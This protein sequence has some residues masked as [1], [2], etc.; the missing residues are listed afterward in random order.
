LFAQPP[1]LYPPP[2]LSP[3]RFLLRFRRVT[4][5]GGF[6]AEIDGL[7][8]IAIFVV[9][10]FHIAVG[11]YIKAPGRF[12]PPPGSA[13]ASV[14]WS[15]FR[16]VE[17]FFII[18]GF[19]LGMP[20]A[21]HHLKGGKKVQ[22]GSYFLRRVTRLE[23]P[24]VL[25]MLG[26]F[27]LYVGIRGRS[28]GALWRHLV[29]SVVYL[30]SLVFGSE[31]VLNN[32]AWSLEVEIQFYLLAPLLAGLFAIRPPS[33]RRAV[34]VA[35]A[36]AA[37][38]LQWAY[39]VPGMRSYLTILRF[40]QFFLVGYL[41]AD[42]YL[43]SDPDAPRSFAWD[44]V[45]VA[46]WPLLFWMWSERGPMLPG[47]PAPRESLLA[48]LAFPV[49]AFFLYRAAFRG[50]ITNVLITNPWVATIGGMCYSIYLLHNPAL[51]MILSATRGI[52]P[53]HS[54]APDL[55]LQLAIAAPLVLVPSAV[56]F[57]LIEKPCMHKDWPRRLVT[58][59][60]SLRPTLTVK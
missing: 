39:V 14:A 55:L 13:M 16:G 36:L 40:L 6:I 28:P 44:L 49:L 18:S 3:S 10:L 8:F 37:T 11:L 33:L 2:T 50:R 56:F 57:A 43:S 12:A 29:A 20:F 52:A 58:W 15:G 48:A 7:R 53:F 9:V 5:S 45:S 17:L 38:A 25:S 30:H 41:L 60:Q 24:Y 42:V 31:S 4:T 23:P 27:V 22:L 34:I 26:L 51:G 19:I 1:A 21:A 46:G 54:Y 32:V 47:L 59:V 35:I